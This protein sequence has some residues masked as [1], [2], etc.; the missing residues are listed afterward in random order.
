M[1]TECAMGVTP[2]PLN[3]IFKRETPLLER[4]KLPER[5]PD[6]VGVNTTVAFTL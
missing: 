3:G 2:V 5:A 6:V 4:D 1:S